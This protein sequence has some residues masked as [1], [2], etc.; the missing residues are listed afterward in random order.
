MI[1]VQQAGHRGVAGFIQRVG[2]IAGHRLALAAGGEDL[3]QQRVV[4]VARFD[5]IQVTARHPQ[6]EGAVVVGAAGDLVGAQRQP[7]AQLP[8]P[9]DQV[10]LQ[11]APVGYLPT[12]RFLRYHGQLLKCHPVI[13]RHSG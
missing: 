9:G 3:Q 4:G 1:F 7:L 10:G 12:V 6:R 11:T 2:V 8:H 13:P 5:Q